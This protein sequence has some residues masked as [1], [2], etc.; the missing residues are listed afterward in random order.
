MSPIMIAFAFLAGV[1]TGIVATFA[2]AAY[3]GGNG[4]AAQHVE[5]DPV[6]PVNGLYVSNLA[7]EKVGVPEGATDASLTPYHVARSKLFVR[8][9]FSDAIVDLDIPLIEKNIEHTRFP[10][11]EDEAH[12][13]TGDFPGLVRAADLIGQL[14]DINYLRKQPALF[15][16]FRETGASEKL[17]YKS[18]ADLRDNYPDFFWQKVRPYI[19]DALRYLRI[20]QEG[21]QWVANLYANVFSME[22]RSLAPIPGPLL[23]APSD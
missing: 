16:E 11:P 12:K 21:K 17:G 13:S 23:N 3:L 22:H 1:V 2:F 10:V 5:P 7:G 9:R 14:A 8:Q 4:R 20:T 19:G 6:R 15:N 18:V